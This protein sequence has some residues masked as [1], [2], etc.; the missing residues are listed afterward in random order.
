MSSEYLG[1]ERR[2]FFRYRHE[3]GV[4][5]QT[6]GKE[7]GRV[8][9]G[10]DFINAISKDLSASGI[11]FTSKYI[12]DISSVLV[13]DLDY[14]TSRVCQEIEERALIVNNKLVGKVVRIEENNDGSYDVGV[15]FVKKSDKLSKNIREF[16]SR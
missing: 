15:A 6:L 10:T 8:D 13:M 11:L 4:K 9:I 3:E 5:Y 1:R 12:P 7:A 2:E 16:I 14:R